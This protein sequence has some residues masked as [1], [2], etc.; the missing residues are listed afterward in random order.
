M[1]YT[2]EKDPRHHHNRYGAELIKGGRG[3]SAKICRAAPILQRHSFV[4]LMPMFASIT[5]LTIEFLPRLCSFFSSKPGEALS[6]S[7][8][9]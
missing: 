2:V 3:G 7:G 9:S 1:E 5:I 4:S 8:D 6:N